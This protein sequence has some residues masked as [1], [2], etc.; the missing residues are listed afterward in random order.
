VDS[1]GKGRLLGRKDSKYLLYVP[2][3]AHCNS[4]CQFIFDYGSERIFEINRWRRYRTEKIV[5]TTSDCSITGFFSTP[6]K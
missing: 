5:R 3:F 4:L 2:S 6:I 1:G